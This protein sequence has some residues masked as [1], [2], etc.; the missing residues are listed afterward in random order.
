[1]R[2]AALRFRGFKMKAFRFRGL[3]RGLK[4]RALRFRGLGL[5]V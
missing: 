4:R 1:M 3:C 2:A 5:G